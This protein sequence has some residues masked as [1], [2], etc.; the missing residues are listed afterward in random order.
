MCKRD[1][2]ALFIAEQCVAMVLDDLLRSGRPAAYL[3]VA[4]LPDV[5]GGRLPAIA[6]YRAITHEGREH[7]GLIVCGYTL[8]DRSASEL[9][10]LLSRAGA[11]LRD[12]A[13]PR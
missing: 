13:P 2:A 11:A 6:E 3:P 8:A 7:S 12:E 9:V 4:Y 10:N 5:G 1:D